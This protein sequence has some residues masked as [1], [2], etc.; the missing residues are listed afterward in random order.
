MVGGSGESGGTLSLL[1]QCLAPRSAPAGRPAS[2]VRTI[3]EGWAGTHVGAA[4]S[5]LQQLPIGSRDTRTQLGQLAWEAAGRRIPLQ[6]PPVPRA[7]AASPP[8]T[9]AP[10]S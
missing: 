1:A 4:G 8:H 7:A 2:R 3:L 6:V 10:A 5:S 9:A